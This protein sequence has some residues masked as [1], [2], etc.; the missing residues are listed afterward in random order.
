VRDLDAA[1][2][3][4]GDTLGFSLKPGRLHENG[5]RNVH[6]RFTDGSELELMSV[7]AGEADE[8]SE[9]YERFLER[10]DGGAFLALGAG[11]VD[12]VI[13]R[14]GEVADEALVFRGPAFDWVAFPRHHW[15]H[16]IYFVHVRDRPAD[17]DWQLRHANGALGLSEVWVETADIGKLSAVLS[18]LGAA[19]CGERAGSGGVAGHAYALSGGTLVVV[20]VGG[21]T[22]E[23]RVTRVNLKGPAGRSAVR[24]GGVWLA[25]GGKGP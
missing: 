12:S 6:I 19:S 24:A 25:W 4:F 21:G 3:L 17:E 7:G 13:G 1:S 9:A 2:S 5:L 16:P 23:R 8:L 14:L 15:L 18:R 10:G 20:E 11:P 22:M